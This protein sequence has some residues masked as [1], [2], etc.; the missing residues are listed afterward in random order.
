[1]IFAEDAVCAHHDSYRIGDGIQVCLQ[2]YF[3]IQDIHR[4]TYG[5]DT[6]SIMS[7]KDLLYV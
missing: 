4:Q 7:S 5:N 1:M 6:R 2:I 3:G